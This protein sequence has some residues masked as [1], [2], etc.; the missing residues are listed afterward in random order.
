MATITTPPGGATESEAHPGLSEPSMEDILASIRR[1]IAEDQSSGMGRT[2][3]GG[4]ARRTTLAAAPADEPAQPVAAPVAESALAEPAPVGDAA[5]AHDDDL[6]GPLDADQIAAYVPETPPELVAIHVEPPPP[7]MADHAHIP[8]PASVEDWAAD[9]PLISPAA[10][11]SIQSSFHALAESMVM[12]D[13]AMIERSVR[14]AIRP[15]LKEWLDDNLP[16]IVERLV[17][18]EIERVARGGQS[19][20]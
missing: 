6:H 2:G 15:M 19:R 14:E 3:L 20:D 18:A 4:F 7:P 10:G 8:A 9:A 16:S 17:R 1:I 5:P 12:Q 13:P 11:A